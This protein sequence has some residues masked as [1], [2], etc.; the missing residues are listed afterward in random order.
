MG[1]HD[2][3]I[4]NIKTKLLI[5]PGETVVHSGHG[6]STTIEEEKRS[7]PFLK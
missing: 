3:L 2:A 7:N 5:L 1:D 6:S 4:R